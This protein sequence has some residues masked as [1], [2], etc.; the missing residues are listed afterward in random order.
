MFWVLSRP[1]Q[2]INR[3]EKINWLWREGGKRQ[4]LCR[5]REQ[6]EHPKSSFGKLE[7]R[8]CKAVC[9]DWAVDMLEWMWVRLSTLFEFFTLLSI[10]GLP[11]AGWSREGEEEKCFVQIRECAGRK[12]REEIEKSKSFRSP[13]EIDAVWMRMTVNKLKWFRLSPVAR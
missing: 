13:W 11:M 2:L 6:R 7:S 4:R 3:G 8:F 1:D 10:A 12:K 9:S 5:W